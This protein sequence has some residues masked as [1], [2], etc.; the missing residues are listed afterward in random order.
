MVEAFYSACLGLRPRRSACPR[1]LY[2]SRLP[3]PGYNDLFSCAEKRDSCG[4]S[5]L[6]PCGSHQER[7]LCREVLSQLALDPCLACKA[8]VTLRRVAPKV[9]A[10]ILLP[11]RTTRRNALPA[12]FC[13][14]LRRNACG[15]VVLAGS[16]EGES[17]GLHSFPKLCCEALRPIRGRKISRLAI[18]PHSSG[19]G[20]G[21]TQTGGKKPDRD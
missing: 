19:S 13:R 21:E 16:T 6:S 17:L 8:H 12:Q 10:V 5:P 1:F 3:G 15:K 20:S 4:T 2:L 7:H 9:T 18:C 14:S 11:P